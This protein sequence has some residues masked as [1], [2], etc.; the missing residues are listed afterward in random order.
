M[1]V[2]PHYYPNLISQISKTYL[3]EIKISIFRGYGVNS[4]EVAQASCGYMKPHLLN[5]ESLFSSMCYEGGVRW[6]CSHLDNLAIQNRITIFCTST[7]KIK[8][9]YWWSYKSPDVV[10]Y[11]N[12]D[13][14]K[15]VLIEIQKNVGRLLRD[16]DC[17]NLFEI[18]QKNDVL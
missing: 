11:H 7:G 2:L 8:E 18:P 1:T 5:H 16:F 13:A 12:Y 6:K 15:S 4:H 10:Q 3:K 14:K 17:K 9:C